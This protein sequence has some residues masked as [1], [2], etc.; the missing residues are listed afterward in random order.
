MAPNIELSE[1]RLRSELSEARAEQDH[2][3]ESYNREYV[4]DTEALWERIHAAEAHEARY[5]P[6]CACP[7]LFTQSVESSDGTA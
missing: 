5:H 6:T 1:A 4:K 2:L 7:P 3:H